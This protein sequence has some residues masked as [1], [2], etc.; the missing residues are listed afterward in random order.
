M[1]MMF[2][3]LENDINLDLRQQVNY[4]AYR[5]CNNKIETQ[6]VLKLAAE[7]DPTHVRIVFIFRNDRCFATHEIQ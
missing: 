4:V 1:D 3:S 5:D 6:Q 2:Q 7:H